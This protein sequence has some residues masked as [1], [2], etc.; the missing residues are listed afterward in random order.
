[1]DKKGIAIG[2]SDFKD[3]IEKKAYYVDKTKFIEEVIKDLST[4]K[5]FTRPRRFGKTLNMTM[6]KYFFD[7]REKE[8][9]RSLFKDLYIKKSSYFDRQGEYPVLFISL[10]DLKSNNWEDC[11]EEIQFLLSELFKEY[12]DIVPS[13]DSKEQ[14]LFFAY[15]NEKAT[16]VKLKRAFRFLSEV[17]SKYYQKKIILLIDEYD[18]PII[19]A[20]QHGYYNEAV[21]FFKTLLSSALKDNPYLEMAVLTGI[22]RVAN[23][24]IFSGLNNLQ[25]YTILDDK[26]ADSFGLTE[27]EVKHAVDYYELSH[28]LETVKAWYNGYRFGGIDIYNPWSITNYLFRGTT[29]VYWIHTS[30]NYLVKKALKLADNDIFDDL[31]SLLNDKAIKVDV[32]KNISFVDMEKDLVSW[33]MLLFGGYLTIDEKIDDSRYTLKLPNY[34]VRDYFKR[35]FIELNFGGNSEFRDMMDAFVVEDF[36]TFETKLN[37]LMMRSLAPIDIDKYEKPY[38][39]FVLGLMAYLSDKYYISSNHISGKGRYDIAM[40]PIYQSQTGFIIEFKVAKNK[41]DF[42]TKAQLAIEQIREKQYYTAMRERKIGKIY[43][44]A[45]VFYAKEVKVDV[46]LIE[47]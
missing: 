45:M 46:V 40:E 44:V 17:V 25:V 24:N 15:R 22:V 37:K 43:A 9:N 14:E 18:T 35:E 23:E 32:N 21:N 2:N 26:Y 31:R 4:V 28:N 47:E 42:T 38:H 29:E 3:I 7:I 10:K 11:Y 16:V 8:C 39:M 13:L 36:S 41:K 5:L 34:E 19:S 33:R 27:N 1:M 20:Y 12:F 30:G 6:L